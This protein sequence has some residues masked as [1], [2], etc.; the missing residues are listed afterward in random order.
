MASS[1]GNYHR[2]GPYFD[3]T[4]FASWKHKMKM[5]ILGHNPAVWA[6]VHVGLQGDFSEDG[7]E[8]DHE[9]TAEE[10][11]MLQYNAQACDILFNGLC[12][13]EFN[14]ISRLEN[15]K[16]IWDTLVDMHE[17]TESVKESKLDV[18]QSQLDKFKMKDGEGVAEMYSRLALITNEIAGLGSEEMTDKFIIKKILRALDGKYDT[19]C[20]LIQMMPNYKDLKPTEVIGRIVAHEMS[21]KD[22]E[23]LH[24]KSSGA[25][26]ASSDAPTTSSDKLVSNEEISLMVK[27]FNKFYKNRGKERSSNSRYNENRSSS[28]DRVCY[29]CGRPRHFSNECTA[30]P[31]KRDESPR[32]KSRRDESPR[33]E[34]RSREDRYERRPSRRSKDSERRDKSTKRYSRRRPQAH[35]GEWVSGS[36]SDNQSERSYHSNSDYSQDEGVAGL[37]LVSSK[38]YDLFDSPNEGI[39]RCF[40][41][42]GPKVTHPEVH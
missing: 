13:E 6:V 8:P 41:A 1:E 14:K 25:Y 17:G 32:R 22:K 38:S 12:P 31:K 16:E 40:M 10:L 37:A 23:E 28:H 21:L 30:P 5:H 42:K 24:N 7:K 33:R 4:N 15:A 3:G 18:L 34:R 20:T 9:A 26:K 19:V 29:N 36:D 11:K 39:G 35:V 27:N 2:R